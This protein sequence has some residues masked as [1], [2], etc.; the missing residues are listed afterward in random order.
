MGLTYAAIVL[1][2]GGVISWLVVGLIAGWLAGVVMKGGGFGIIGDIVVGLIGSFLGGLLTGFFVEGSAQFWGSIVVAFIGACV[3]IA[4]VRLIG[5]RQATLRTVVKESIPENEC[6]RA[7]EC[8]PFCNKPFLSFALRHSYSD[9][10]SFTNSEA[11]IVTRYENEYSTDYPREDRIMATTTKGPA[12][13]TTRKRTPIRV[14]PPGRRPPH[15]RRPSPHRGGP[16]PRDRRASTGQEALRGRESAQRASSQAHGRCA[17][18]N[19]ASE[20]VSSRARAG[21]GPRSSPS[22]RPGLPR[23]GAT[24]PNAAR[25]HVIN[26]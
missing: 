18:R 9:L 13:A 2:P 19:R 12:T 22:R 11:R 1:A 5:G 7:N 20:A 23:R 6:R 3:L 24:N 10:D 25:R 16:P 8:K 4:L 26:R 15:G 14:P 17:L 21:R